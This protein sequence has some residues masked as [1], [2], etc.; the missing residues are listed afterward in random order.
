LVSIVI[1]IFASLAVFSLLCMAAAFWLGVRIGDLQAA[2]DPN[3]S[4]VVRREFMDRSRLHLLTGLAA[5]LVVILVNSISVTY[6]IGTGRWCKEVVERYSLNRSLI[7][8]STRLKRRTFPWAVLSMM[9]TVSAAA[10][11]AASDPGTLLDN[12]AAWV[13]PH[14]VVSILT[15]A[16]LACSFFVQAR[17]LQAHSNLIQDIMAKVRRVREERGLPVEG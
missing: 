17:N 1:R 7:K 14:F 6:F 11:G 5:A 3:V 16:F 9:T 8:L 2:A 10:L 13:T 12:T 15:L 4:E